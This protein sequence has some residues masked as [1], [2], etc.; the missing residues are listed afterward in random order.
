MSIHTPLLQI[1]RERESLVYP[2]LAS[3]NWPA[4]LN[5]STNAIRIITSAQFIMESINTDNSQTASQV[6]EAATMVLKSNYN[7]FESTFQV[8]QYIEDVIL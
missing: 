2:T 8:E 5:I 7:F 4:S 6:L 3:V 1:S